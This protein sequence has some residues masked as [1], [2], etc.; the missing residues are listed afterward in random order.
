MSIKLSPEHGVN[1]MLLQCPLCAGDAGI[2]LLGRLSNDAK[3]PRQGVLPGSGPC[4]S[5]KEMMSKGF[6]LIEVT[7]GSDKKNPFRT[8]NQYV[9]AHEF[10]AKLD[11]DTSRGAAFIEERSVNLLGLKNVEPLERH[12][13]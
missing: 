6:L 5:C 13:E 8:G 2:A 1:P 7:D 12:G 10:V 9:M 4:S 11:I 3:A